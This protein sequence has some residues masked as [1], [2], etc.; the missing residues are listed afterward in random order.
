MRH[1][2][3]TVTPIEWESTPLY[4][5]TADGCTTTIERGMAYVYSGSYEDRYGASG[6][7]HYVR[8]CVDGSE[9]VRAYVCETEPTGVGVVPSD[10]TDRALDM[11]RESV[12]G[13]IAS[14]VDDVADGRRVLAAAT[15]M[16]ESEAA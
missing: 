12:D 14:G 3:D 10:V 16:A 1:S 5:Y 11:L 4:S 2:P 8:E 13:W 9:N 15:S 6:E 7:L